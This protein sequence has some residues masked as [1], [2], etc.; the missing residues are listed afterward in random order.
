[1][2]RTVVVVASLL[3]AALALV[4]APLMVRAQDGGVTYD[5][6]TYGS[7]GYGEAYYG[8][9]WG[10]GYGNCY[11]GGA[12]DH[13][14]RL[15][16][17]GYLYGNRYVVAYGDTSYSIAQRFGITVNALA[18]A[19]GINA[20]HIYAGQKLYIPGYG[21]GGCQPQPQPTPR[22]QPQPCNGDSYANG[23]CQPQPC[24]YG[25]YCQPQPCYGGGYCPPTKPPVYPTPVTP[26]PTE[27]PPEDEVTIEITLPERDEALPETFPV[28]GIVEGLPVGA[29]I[30]VRA[31]DAA[32]NPLEETVTTVQAGGRAG[33]RTFATSLTVLLDAPAQGYIQAYP[34]DTRNPRDSVRVLF[35]GSGGTDE[36]ASKEF[37]EDECRVR[38]VRDAPYYDEPGG[39]ETGQFGSNRRYEVVRGARLDDAYWF[40]VGPLPTT[41]ATVW[42]PE[43]SVTDV[44]A[45]CV[46]W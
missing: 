9:N 45:S 4:I 44:L 2:K 20:W 36:P 37:G 39:A 31:L 42:A 13:G 34:T 15:H 22:P 14:P 12:Y 7:G 43:D 32:R 16:A 17:Q 33:Q 6:A 28:R 10:G 40:L 29:S 23:Y 41:G 19:N 1:M 30:T 21:G 11:G 26:Q 8:G 46:G 25:G 3:L 5:G 24:Y 38:V 35:G 18:Q 27:E